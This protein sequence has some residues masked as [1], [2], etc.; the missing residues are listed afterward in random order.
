MNVFKKNVHLN[1][2]YMKF[3]RAK[4]HKVDTFKGFSATHEEKPQIVKLLILYL[5]EKHFSVNSPL[6][7][8]AFCEICRVAALWM[9]LWVQLKSDCGVHLSFELFLIKCEML[10]F[11]KQNVLTP[12]TD[13]LK[14][15]SYVY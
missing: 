15:M 5:K 7:P 3:H 2:P 12:Y 10:S 11:D 14:T 8:F 6:A 9:A 13:H 1:F 4:T